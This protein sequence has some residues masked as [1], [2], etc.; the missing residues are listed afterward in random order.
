MGFYFWRKPK[1]AKTF[2]H[3]V[4]DSG[5]LCFACE[6]LRFACE[7]LRFVESSGNRRICEVDSAESWNLAW[8]LRD[9]VELWNL[10]SFCY[11]LLAK[12]RIPSPSKPQFTKR[13]NFAE[14]ALDSINLCRLV[15]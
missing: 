4:R 5:I 10:K 6:I 13:G 11:F 1:V 12:S 3:L 8:N 14:S 9:F 7:I 2:T 15:N